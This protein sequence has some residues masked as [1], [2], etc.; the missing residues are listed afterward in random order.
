MPVVETNTTPSDH[1]PTAPMPTAHLFRRQ[2]AA[3]IEGPTVSARDTGADASKIKIPLP[4]A[5]TLLS[6]AI[7]VAAGVWR[8]ENKVGKIETAIM[9][10]RELDTQRSA[11][12][13]E[14]EQDYRNYIDQRFETLE[15]KIDAAGL[16]N[17]N[18]AL[19][20]ELSKQRGR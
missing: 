14:R 17:A 8:I 11:R 10:E 20:Q 2:D 9:Y 18:M 12:Q 7:L 19:A 5:V 16:R 3:S 15:S 6:A 13:A 4:M 1:E